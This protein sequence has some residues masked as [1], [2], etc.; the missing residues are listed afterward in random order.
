MDCWQQT[1]ERKQENS[2][3]RFC[4]PL[5]MLY[6]QSPKFCPLP[7]YMKWTRAKRCKGGVNPLLK[8]SRKCLLL[9]FHSLAGRWQPLKKKER[10]K[11]SNKQWV[12][13]SMKWRLSKRLGTRK[14]IGRNFFCLLFSLFKNITRESTKQGKKKKN[15]LMQL[16]YFSPFFLFL[17]G[18]SGEFA[19][20]F[21]I[22]EKERGKKSDK[23]KGDTSRPGKRERKKGNHF[24]F[25]P[26]SHFFLHSIY[27]SL[28]I[29][30]LL[31]ART[32]NA[33]CT[34][35]VRG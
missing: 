8:V 32:R 6:L 34:Y 31:P 10:K 2:L 19:L 22:W 25:P 9:R 15:I 33:P 18:F 1:T 27:A 13:L 29:A 21:Y 14:K 3:T 24:P 11:E 28:F 30:F 5:F 7:K 16:A 20:L 4:P 23:K 26:L 35:S 17:R 12:K